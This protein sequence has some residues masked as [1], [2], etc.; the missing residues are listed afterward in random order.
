MIGAPERAARPALGRSRLSRQGARG[1][2]DARGRRSAPGHRARPVDRAR[3][4]EARAGSRLLSATGATT[5]ETAIVLPVVVVMVLVILVV[6]AGIGIRVQLESAARTAARELARGESES[7]AIASALR[8]A[9]ADAQVGIAADGEWVRVEVSRTLRGPGGVLSGAAWTLHGD[10]VARREPHLLSASSVPPAAAIGLLT[11]PAHHMRFRRF[12]R[13]KRHRRL[14]HPRPPLRRAPLRP[15]RRLSGEDGS[16]VASTLAW[17]GAMHAVLVAVLITGQ[18]LLAQAQADTAADLAALAGADA[19]AAASVEP[20]TAAE[21]AVVRNGAR[22]ESCVIEG[23]TVRVRASVHAG[24]L[25]DAL[26][27][28]RAGPAPHSP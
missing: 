13:F 21:A 19:L 12:K 27:E 3:S 28:A 26:S 5:A 9:G 18:L 25:P 14:R 10:A 23:S 8:V 20:C 6:G 24:L 4:I 1:R 16:A 2:R 22:L 11:I 15:R 17:I 7:S